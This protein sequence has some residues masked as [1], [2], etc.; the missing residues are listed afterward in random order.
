V[1]ES[2]DTSGRGV[3]DTIKL[4]PGYSPNREVLETF[5]MIFYHI[6]HSGL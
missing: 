4:S 1:R 3:T 2:G 5:H 6:Y